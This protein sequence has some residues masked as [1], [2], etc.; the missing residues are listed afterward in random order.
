MEGCHKLENCVCKTKVMPPL[1]YASSNPL[2]HPHPCPLKIFN[3]DLRLMSECQVKMA[4]ILSKIIFFMCKKS[5]AHLQY[6]CNNCA[7]FQLNA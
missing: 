1:P 4:V 2:A 3:R 5:H 7:K 6:A